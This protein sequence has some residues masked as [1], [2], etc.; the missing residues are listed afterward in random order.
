MKRLLGGG[1]PRAP[2]PRRRRAI[3]GSAAVALATAG[4]F[5]GTAHGQEVPG[6]D[7]EIDGNLVQ[8]NISFDD[9][10]TVIPGP[11][12][13]GAEGVLIPDPHSKSA[14]DTNVFNSGGKFYDTSTWN[15]G[16]GNVGAAQNELTNVAVY[17]V[18]SAQSSDGDDWLVLAL[19]R[20]KKQGTFALWLEFNQVTWD[21]AQASVPT[22]STGD[23]AVGF[24]LSGNP[25]DE[26]DFQVAVLAFDSSGAP[27][28]CAVAADDTIGPGTDA[29]PEFNGDWHYRYLG[30][31]GDLGAIGA[32]EM[33]LVDVPSTDWES[34]DAQ[35]NLRD[36]IGPFQFAEAAL[37][38]NELG[39]D[40]GCP[41]FGSAH[42]ATVAS[43]SSTADAKDL[44]GPQDL[45]ITCSI[46]GSKYLDVNVDGAFDAGDTK[47][48]GWPMS[49]YADDG[50][51]VFD[52]DDTQVG[53]TILTDTSGDYLFTGLSDGVY[54]V[55]EGAARDGDTADDWQHQAARSTD[56]TVVN[57]ANGDPTIIQGI[58]INSGNTTSTGN[59]F[60]NAQPPD[61]NVLKV[62]F[63]GVTTIEAGDDAVFTITIGND[64]P[65]TATNVSLT[66]NL[67]QLSTDN[68]WSITAQTGTDC[69][70][71]DDDP[72]TGAQVLSC[73]VSSLAADA[74]YEVTVTATTTGEDCDDI[75]NSATVSAGN[76]PAGNVGDDNTA[77]A[78]I[79]VICPD[80]SAAKSGTISYTASVSN[81]AGDAENPV[82]TADGVTLTDQLP[83]DLTWTVTAISEG[84]ADACGLE[85]DDTV[86][87]GLI[88]CSGIELAP[89]ASFEVSV[90]ASIADTT[91]GTD[92]PLINNQVS[93]S[94]T[95]EAAADTSNNSAGV[96]IC[97]APSP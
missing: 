88:D 93:G 1:R 37:N 25:E 72:A 62:A 56:G 27:D 49:L 63:D 66:D 67:P 31:A 15:I 21:A 13:L 69:S 53:S 39:I 7:F 58:P 12:S 45:P 64:G 87:G 61:V 54:H 78:T 60:L 95:N 80:L 11:S 10:E 46:G 4:L 41:G 89:G 28:L 6:P 97:P 22:R 38:L 71:S 81:A 75:V 32:G 36:N 94:A 44:G 19:E 55:V 18:T 24:E 47:I 20:T 50:D 42:A 68:A 29:C 85:V 5:A 77:T 73:S 82:A 33:N 23:I 2:H 26:S 14:T 52:A 8:D 48:S 96:A 76:E 40:V 43:L 51:G 34:Y 3:A 16:T 83:G 9:W 17:P 35:G 59:D 65:G 92:T 91:C 84:G 86:P 70:I 57:D 90:S 79:T 74:E 30:P